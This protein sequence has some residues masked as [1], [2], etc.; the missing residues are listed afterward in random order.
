[1]R[2]V[3]PLYALV[4]AYSMDPF[5]EVGIGTLSSVSDVRSRNA[6]VIGAFV[7]SISL[8]RMNCW[9]EPGPEAVLVASTKRTAL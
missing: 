5:S 4:A 7:G 6:G 9:G 8:A 1:M 2:T 3:R